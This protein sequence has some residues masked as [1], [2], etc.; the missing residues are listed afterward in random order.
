[1][2][3]K[4]GDTAENFASLAVAAGTAGV[5]METVGAASAKL[6]KNLTGVDDESKEAGAAIKA[7]GLNLKDFKNKAPTDQLEAVAKALGGFED[8]ASKTAVAMALFGKSGAELLPFLKELGAEGGRQVILTASRS[9]GRRVR[10]P[11]GEAARADQPARAGARHR[12]APDAQRLQPGHRGPASDQQVAAVAADLLKSSL[13]GAIVIF[14]TI[15]VVASDVA[16]VFQGV[17][18]EIGAIAA[19]LAALA[20]LDFAGF[21]AISDAVKDDAV[22]ARAELDKFQ[23][24]IMAIGQPAERDADAEREAARFARQAQQAASSLFNGADKKRQGQGEQEAKARLALDLEQIKAASE[25]SPRSTRTPRRSWRRS[26]PP[27]AGRARLLR[28]KRAFMRLNADEQERELQ[29]EI[30]RMQREQSSVRQGPHRQRAQDRRG[31]APSCQGAAGR[32]AQQIV[33]DT[34]EAAAARQRASA[35]LSARRPRRTT[36]TSRSASNART[37]QHRAGQPQRDLE[38]RHQ[39]D[40]GPLRAASAATWRTPRPAGAGRQVHQGSRDQY[41]ERLRSS[42]SSSRSRSTATPA[43]TPG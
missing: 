16:F 17:G 9:A 14:Q 1:M 2:A 24:R 4:F 29:A 30:A 25:A 31:C 23:A 43:T 20:R 32:R 12:A 11:P 3:E 10:R 34:Q 21:N 26:A 18:R 37:R 39:P 13:N 41:D 5:Q 6:T 19:Q 42:T 22:R 33:L 40:R 15:A 28:A 36:T 27:A 38:R 8:G 7:L 35:L